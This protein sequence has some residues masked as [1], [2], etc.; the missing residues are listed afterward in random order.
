MT[1]KKGRPTFGD[2][3]MVTV[4]IRLPIKTNKALEKKGSKRGKSAEIRLAIDSY[5]ES[6]N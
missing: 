1:E 6:S 3:A 4:S 5:L 2:K